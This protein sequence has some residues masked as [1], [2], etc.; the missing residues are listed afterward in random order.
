MKT[1]DELYRDILA[2]KV[3]L[4]APLPPEYEPYHLDCLLHPERNAPVLFDEP[5]TDC[6]YERACQNSCIFDAIEEGSDG[7]LF[8]NPNLCTGCGVCIDACENH[9]ISA[10]K[11]ILPAM[12]AVREAKGPAYMMVAPAFLGQFTENVTPGKLRTAFRALGFSGM[13]EVALFADILTLKEALEF[14]KHILEKGD[15]QLTSCCC[16]VWIAM[17]RKMYKELMPH[18]PG[19]VSPM[20]ACGRMIKLLH[21]D[22]VTVFAGPCLAKKSEAREKDV[23]GA[24]DY[25][26]TFQEV[27]DIFEAADIHPEELEDQEKEHSSRAGRI[28]ARTGGVSE[29]VR[30]TERQLRPDRKIK[31]KAEQADGIQDCRALI[32]RIQ[33]Q[34]TDANFF[35]GMGCPG[36]CVG[37]PKAILNKD[38][39][40]RFVDE[41]GDQALFA[42]PLENPYVMKMLEKLGF[43][44]VEDFIENSELLVRD[45]S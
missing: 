13:V 40:K 3:S 34:E 6:A 36:G 27:Q 4:K 20:V 29:A 43:T 38:E 26:L 18:V 31:V 8:I 28:Y 7:K 35:E 44:S 30:E 24:V 25:V 37:G 2:Q 22:A 33:N 42:T 41:Y 45:F 32:S 21:P 14:D 1:F 15:Y 16:P 19:A 11:D 12:K 39:G 10:G 17:I 5:C 9:N 23:A